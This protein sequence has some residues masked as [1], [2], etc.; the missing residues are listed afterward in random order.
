VAN[1]YI[2]QKNKTLNPNNH[3]SRYISKGMK[4]RFWLLTSMFLKINLISITN[5]MIFENAHIK[6]GGLVLKVLYPFVLT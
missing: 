5:N 1:G 3:I 4:S 6:V 2:F